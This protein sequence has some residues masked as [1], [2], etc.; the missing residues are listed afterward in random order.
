MSGKGKIH[1]RR[2][3]EFGP[4]NEMEVVFEHSKEERAV[5]ELNVPEQASL[6]MPYCNRKN[7]TRKIH[8]KLEPD[9]RYLSVIVVSIEGKVLTEKDGNRPP[10][11]YSDF[12]ALKETRSS[13]TCVM[14]L[15]SKSLSYDATS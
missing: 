1:E 5:A 15:S 13:A 11:N 2:G 14:N 12:L 4:F 7:E 10:G 9:V 3:L 8:V 6:P